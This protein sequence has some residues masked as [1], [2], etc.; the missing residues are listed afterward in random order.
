MN[1]PWD[2][3]VKDD[4]VAFVM[5]VHVRR[6]RDGT[7]RSHRNLQGPEDHLAAQKMEGTHGMQEG[8][9]ALLTEA[10]RSEAMLQLL[11]KLTKLP[12][13][14]EKLLSGAE[15]DENLLG[16]LSKDTLEQMQ[17]G[18]EEL[19]PSLVK[20]AAQVVRDGLQGQVE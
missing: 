10:A 18:L 13:F 6:D 4:Y 11:V 9:W 5:E 2:K 3:G 19:L 14:K 7:I 17:K 16:S 1:P 15:I 12:D 8:S 20:E